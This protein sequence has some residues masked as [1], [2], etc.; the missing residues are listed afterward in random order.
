[1]LG[2]FIGFATG[3]ISIFAL[4]FFVAA[5]KDDKELREDDRG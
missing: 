4:A 5:V 2:F 3:L 1:M